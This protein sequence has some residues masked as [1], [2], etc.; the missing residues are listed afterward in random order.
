V[1]AGREASDALAFAES[2]FH[3]ERALELLELVPE[4]ADGLE[5][6][7]ARLLRWAAESAHLAAHPD[8]ATQLI[9]LALARAEPDDVTLQG[10]LHER[11]GRYLWMGGDGRGAL[12]AYERAV[13]LVPAEP[14]S[15]AR[16]SVLSGLSQILMLG[17]RY[18]ESAAYARAAIDVARQVPDGRSIEGHARCNLGVDLAFLGHVEEGLVE[19]RT[20]LRIADDELDDVDENARALVNL[21]SVLLVA[22]R[23]EE[24]AEAALEGVR[25]GDE[26]GLRRRKGIWCRCDAA[27]VLLVLGRFDEAAALLAEGRDIDPQG[28]DAF[29][30]DLVEGQLLLR[31][32]EFDKARELLER[33][34]AASRRLLDPQL[35]VPLYAALIEVAV[36]QGD[37][38]AAGLADEG[39][40]RIDLETVHPV[41]VAE[42]AASATRAALRQGDRGLAE[43]WLGRGQALVDRTPADLAEPAVQLAMARAEVADTVESWQ[44]SLTRWEAFGDPYRAAYTRFRLGAALLA[45][46]GDRIQAAEHLDTAHR[47]AQELGAAHLVAEADDLARRARLRVGAAPADNPYRLTARE[48]E[49]LALVAEGLTDRAIGGRLFISHRTVE[50]HVSNLLAKLAADRRSELVAT[51]LREGLVAS[52]A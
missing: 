28:V 51:A 15:R 32:G 31:R 13:A 25:V 34:R 44:E 33:G 1:A 46:G 27:Q 49:I 30:V 35:I 8:R 43:T 4:E 6:A 16:A 48:R 9:R 45:A 39:L 2:L 18:D 10:W 29:R 17:D 50:R 24:A 47:R 12:T 41:Y 26:L 14:P 40:A 7:P 36:W 21:Q 20:A 23:L 3:Y 52:G 22:G 19:L 11:L 42:L 38:A 5:V 37:G